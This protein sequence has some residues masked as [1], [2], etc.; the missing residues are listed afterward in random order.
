MFGLRRRWVA[1]AIVLLLIVLSV[2]ALDGTLAI[3]SYRVTD[4]HTLVVQVGESPG[5]WTRVTN[6]AETTS[7][8]TITVSSLAFRPGPGTAEAIL[9]EVSVTLHDPIGNRTVIDG[10]TGLLVPRAP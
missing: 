1:L 2:R 7:A 8:V 5:A 10:S 9:I 6:V 3:A 4:D